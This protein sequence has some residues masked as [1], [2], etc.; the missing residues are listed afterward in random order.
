MTPVEP[1]NIDRVELQPAAE[2]AVAIV[3]P[4]E[5]S[6]QPDTST[7]LLVP[8]IFLCAALLGGLRFGAADNAFLFLK[9]P[10]VCLVF[11]AVTMVLFFAAAWSRMTAGSRTNSRLSR[12][13]RMRL[14]S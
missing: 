4:R 13:R 5:L 7:Y 10:L 14:C 8:A 3:E 1:E 9:P 11:A 12:T 2:E 6:A